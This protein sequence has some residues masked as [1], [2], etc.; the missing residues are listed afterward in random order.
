LGELL[1]G[2]ELLLLSGQLGSGKTC[3]TQGVAWGIGVKEHAR[4]PTF[5]LVSE[6]Q[7]R[8]PLYH[9]DLYRIDELMEME[10]LGLEEYFQRRGVCVIEWAEKAT[11]LLPQENLSITLETTGPQE[12]LIGLSARGVHYETLL[13]K[14]RASYAHGLKAPAGG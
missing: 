4:S 2:G 8:V 9:V 1:Q 5:V 3:L 12:R 10:E 7:G 6:Y 14:L 11:L 13:N